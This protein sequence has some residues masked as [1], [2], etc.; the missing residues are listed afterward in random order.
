MPGRSISR[1]KP[2][3]CSLPSPYAH[4]WAIAL[5]LL[6]G[7]SYSKHLSGPRQG[8]LAG[9]HMLFAWPSSQGPKHSA[10]S[11][12]VQSC[13][14]KSACSCHPHMLLALTK[15]HWGKRSQWGSTKEAETPLWPLL[16]P[17]VRS[18]GFTQRNLS[19]NL[20]S[21]PPTS[22]CSHVSEARGRS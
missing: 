16:Q 17:G 19:A 10:G 2:G 7:Q 20:A 18:R 9:H 8:S 14:P 6:Q 15:P 22:P 11:S 12:L 21:F 3:G 1:A 5:E 4:S 13:P